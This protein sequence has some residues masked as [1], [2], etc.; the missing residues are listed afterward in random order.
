[1]KLTSA[2]AQERE[3]RSKAVLTIFIVD[4]CSMQYAVVMELLQFCQIKIM[5]AKDCRSNVKI[6]EIFGGGTNDGFNGYRMCF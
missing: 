1:M 5:R 6:K 2:P 3:A 4:G